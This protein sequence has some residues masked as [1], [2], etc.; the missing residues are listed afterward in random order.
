MGQR[1]WCDTEVGDHLGI[2]RAGL[3]ALTD[4]F[5]VACLR[6]QGA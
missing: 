6:P 2:D 5:A 3:G 4:D 1:P